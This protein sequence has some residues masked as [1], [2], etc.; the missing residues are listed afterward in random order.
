MFSYVKN[1]FWSYLEL[2]SNI[3]KYSKHIKGVITRLGGKLQKTNVNKMQQ[4]PKPIYNIM[5]KKLYGRKIKNN[6]TWIFKSST[7]AFQST[8][9][10]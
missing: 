9:T 3:Y 6:L 4:N 8:T 10:V 2:K 1:H 7:S 5:E